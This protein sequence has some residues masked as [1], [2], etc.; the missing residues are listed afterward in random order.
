MLTRMSDTPNGDPRMPTS[1]EEPGV[2]GNLPRTRP[3]RASA[4][5]A[6]ARAASVRRR[7]AKAQAKAS[8]VSR[9]GAAK[10]SAQPRAKPARARARKA[11]QAGERVP[12]QG[13]E[14]ESE[15]MRG[16]IQPPGGAELA[17]SIAE[18]AGEL[19]KASVST[20]A[21][22]VKGLLSRLPG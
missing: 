21:H 17:G 9:S 12:P 13:Y 2:L 6:Q 22:F 10:S 14:P 3:Q 8:T 11:E 5:R 1:A 16:P 18:L 19:A 4:R 7:P 20:S 15:S